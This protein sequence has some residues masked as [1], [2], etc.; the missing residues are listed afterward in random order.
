MESCPDAY[1]RYDVWAP[2]DAVRARMAAYIG[3]SVNDTVFVE[4]ASNGVNAVL[5]VS[6]SGFGTVNF[7]NTS[8]TLNGNGAFAQI[9][10][11][12]T[13]AGAINLIAANQTLTVADT[14][15]K[16]STVEVNGANQTINLQGAST[17][18]GAVTLSST[19]AT[20]NV[21]G[22]GA[23]LVVTGTQAG[24]IKLFG[25]G[26]TVYLQG[27]AASSSVELQ[28]SG[29]LYINANSP[30]SFNGQ[31]KILNSVNKSNTVRLYGFGNNL[32][33]DDQATGSQTTVHMCGDEQSVSLHHALLH[34]LQQRS[35]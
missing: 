11:S 15:A 21:N 4:N 22:D 12:G 7:N 16:T 27:T 14:A 3:A 30:Q 32:Y 26:Q 2:Y 9:T 28:G 25:D 31:V 34:Q 5:S 33:V 8:Q 29:A 23:A 6:G 13:Q 20:V 10:V 35:L 19:G 24:T 18:L 17:T 1:F